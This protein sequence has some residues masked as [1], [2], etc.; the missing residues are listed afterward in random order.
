MSHFFCLRLYRAGYG[1]R[2][3]TLLKITEILTT[4]SCKNCNEIFVVHNTQTRKLT[5]E[6][7]QKIYNP[8][9]QQM[10]LFKI[11][12][13]NLILDGHICYLY[14]SFKLKQICS[15]LSLYGR[16]VSQWVFV[17]RKTSSSSLSN[18]LLVTQVLGEAI[19][20]SVVLKISGSGNWNGGS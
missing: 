1:D 2:K 20:F 15:S 14:G 11:F 10:S 16:D 4:K 5:K 6:S 19:A 17:K 3:Q 12:S 8:M 9:L 18:D 7:L 13:C